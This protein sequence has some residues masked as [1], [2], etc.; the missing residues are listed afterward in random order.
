MGNGGSTEQKDVNQEVD[1]Q[2]ASFHI[3]QLHLPTLGFGLMAIFAIILAVVCVYNHKRRE[4]DSKRIQQLQ[5]MKDPAPQITPKDT[6]TAVIP[7]TPVFDQ[8]ALPLPFSYSQPH[9]QPLYAPP[10]T[11]CPTN[12]TPGAVS[13]QIEPST[14]R[15]FFR[16]DSHRA[17]RRIENERKRPAPP[18]DE[19]NGDW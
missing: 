14:L 5:Q 6:P 4:A 10:N 17:P 18:D 16:R 8:R 7:P 1:A 9:L 13:I 11:P 3:V 15:S 19:E 2:D 12:H